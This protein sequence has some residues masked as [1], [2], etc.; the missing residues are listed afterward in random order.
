LPT[1]TRRLEFDAGHRV[2]GHAGKCRFPHGHR[3][4]VEVTCEAPQLDAAGFVVDFGVVKERVG[5]WIDS[6]MDHAFL[7]GSEDKAMLVALESFRLHSPGG[8]ERVLVMLDPPT[9][10]NIAALVLREA[11]RLLADSRLSV[12]HVRVYE[13]PNCWADARCEE[14]HQ[15]SPVTWR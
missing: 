2:P 12:T 3:Y 8:E 4:V 13:T 10:E 14:G 5:G 1:I 7:V 9:A 15:I 6:N 11:R